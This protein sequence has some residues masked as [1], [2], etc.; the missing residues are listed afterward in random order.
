MVSGATPYQPEQQ[1]RHH[2]KSRS[3]ML[4]VLV[5]SEY[6]TMDYQ[7]LLRPKLPIIYSILLD[8]LLISSHRSSNNSS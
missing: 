8:V 1:T 2:S 7:V 6:L 4:P 5:E 3:Y